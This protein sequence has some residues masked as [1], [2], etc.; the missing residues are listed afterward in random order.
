MRRPTK[1]ASMPAFLEARIEDGR[2][3]AKAKGH[4][5]TAFHFPTPAA[6]TKV[7]HC[8]RC[9][10]DVHVPMAPFSKY[11]PDRLLKAVGTAL[12]ET[13]NP[14]DNGQDCD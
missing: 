13:C 12:E 6:N 14:P 10:R 11:L 2:T 7:A 4:T 9:G 3:R 1:T 5:L 8:I